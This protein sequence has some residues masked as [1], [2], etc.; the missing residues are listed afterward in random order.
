MLVEIGLFP[1]GTSHPEENSDLKRNFISLPGYGNQEPKPM[2]LDNAVVY[3]C[4]FR[5]IEFFCDIFT[6]C[7][8]SKV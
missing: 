2:A 5:A 6:F 3:L 8:V 4:L 1:V 7:F